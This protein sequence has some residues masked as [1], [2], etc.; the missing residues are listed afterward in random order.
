MSIK[1]AHA[2]AC[3][4]WA[5]LFNGLKPGVISVNQMKSFENN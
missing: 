3:I 4:M 2:V 1:L 5:S